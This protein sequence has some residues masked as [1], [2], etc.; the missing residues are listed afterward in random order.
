[1]SLPPFLQAT[2]P[3]IAPPSQ[4][5]L[6]ALYASTSA[7]KESNPTGYQA[8]VTWWTGIIEECL[9]TGWTG[10][11]R[12]L[13]RVDEHLLERFENAEGGRAKGLGGVVVRLLMRRAEVLIIRRACSV[14]R[15]SC[16]LFQRL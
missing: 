16:T 13:L 6:R 2:P 7:Q 14:L 15:R 11:H 9:R 1:M 10:D 12:L 5:R 3:P 8:N 4:A